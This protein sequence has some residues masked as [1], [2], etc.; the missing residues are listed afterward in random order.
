GVNPLNVA[1]TG[2]VRRYVDFPRTQRKPADITPAVSGPAGGNRNSEVRSANE[3]YQSGSVYRLNV[4]RSWHPTPTAVHGS[5]AAVVKRS[6]TPRFVIDPGPAPGVY[7]YP[8]P[9][10]IG[11]PSGW[12]GIRIPHVA[13]GRIGTP[14]TVS[15]EVFITDYVA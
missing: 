3:R 12:D 10:A 9:V 14:R 8:V 2:G 6:V 11:S 5:P 4:H 7:P 15:V 1:R 13:I